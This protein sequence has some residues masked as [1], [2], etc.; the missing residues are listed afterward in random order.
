M[1]PFKPKH[2]RYSSVFAWT[3]AEKINGP[4][5]DEKLQSKFMDQLGELRQ[6]LFE[7]HL[8]TLSEV[9]REQLKTGS[10]S[11]QSHQKVKDADEF[12]EQLHSELL[13]LGFD[14]EIR[15]GCYHANR[16]ILSV[17]PDG[18]I[19]RANLAKAVPQFFHGYEVMIL[20]K[21]S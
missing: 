4:I 7:K 8:K 9:E 14:V 21:N 11:S 6:Y 12:A 18:K 15:P 19:D 16:V 2:L 5:A 20:F 1:W 17:F 3:E 10:H 13:R